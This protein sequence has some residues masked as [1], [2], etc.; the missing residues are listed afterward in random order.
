MNISTT[1]MNEYGIAPTVRGAMQWA[2]L[3]SP[4]PPVKIT[5]PQQY[6]GI[7]RRIDRELHDVDGRL[8]AVGVNHVP[9]MEWVRGLRRDGFEPRTLAAFVAF[10][11]ATQ[12]RPGVVGSSYNAEP[13]VAFALWVTGITTHHAK[14]IPS[15]WW[16]RA[17]TRHYW[18]R[19]SP[20]IGRA[21]RRRWE[22]ESLK[23][24]VSPKVLRRLG[25]LPADLQVLALRG[26]YDRAVAEG[27]SR[28]VVRIRHLNWCAVGHATKTPTELMREALQFRFWSY[29]V[30]VTH[31][32]YPQAQS[33]IAV[34][35]LFGERPTDIATFLT[36]K[37]AHEWL[38]SPEHEPQE[39]LRLQV[40]KRLPAIEPFDNGFAHITA[41]CRSTKILRWLDNVFQSGRQTA[42]FKTRTV[43]GPAGMTREFCFA[44]IIDEIQDEDITEG[45]HT[46]VH[47]AF[48]RAE[49]RLAE[50][51]RRTWDDKSPDPLTEIPQWA[52]NLP[53]GVRVLNTAR[54]LYTEGAEMAHCVAG[55]TSAVS[56]RQC[57]ILS[58]RVGDSWSTAE[59]SYDGSRV[60]QHL[61]RHD[62][63]A[64]AEC[65]ELLGKI[66]GKKN[67]N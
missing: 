3:S 28:A 65:S 40:A 32:S 47:K 22:D 14:L 56:K 29:S 31:P 54:D 53:K 11:N 42:L 2:R 50:T 59:V 37:E 67:F 18:W 45:P 8:I 6:V 49:Q 35:L 19:W 7:C 61:S 5:S 25:Q 33:D 1:T 38:C 41:R 46:S 26:A 51:H 20:E 27:G 63:P 15:A 24:R 43:H 48:E 64:P 66:V 39:W 17:A 30:S 21:L 52:Y 16:S 62:A 4:R 57:V 58:I 36:R 10:W 60:F 55:Y 9:P 34:R 12:D 23:Y 44:Q 13:E